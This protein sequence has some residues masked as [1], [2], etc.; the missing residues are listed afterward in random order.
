MVCPLGPD[1]LST[2]SAET[3]KDVPRPS[4]HPSL[5]HTL[6]N[7]GAMRTCSSTHK[8]VCTHTY[9]LKEPCH[10]S[11]HP[12]LT[13]SAYISLL[14]PAS[15]HPLSFLVTQTKDRGERDKACVLGGDL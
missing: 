6:A 10:P 11:H 13:L 8:P 5:Q 12:P 7:S 15:P 3:A 4:M 2:S 9:T 14:L 1:A